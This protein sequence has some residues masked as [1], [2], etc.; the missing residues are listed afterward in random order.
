MAERIPLTRNDTAP[1]LEITIVD[2]ATGE[3]VDLTGGVATLRFR[4]VGSTTTLITRQ[5]FIDPTKA[6][7]GIAYMVWQ[8]GDLNL[9]AGNYEAEVRVNFVGQIR[10]TVRNYLNFSLRDDFT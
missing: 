5:L 4:E 10:Q 1:Q 2:E 9:T 6:P 3:A 8:T 7:Q